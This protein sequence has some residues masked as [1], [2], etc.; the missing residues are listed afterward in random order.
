MYS[1]V[2][3]CTPADRQPTAPSAGPGT[4]TGHTGHT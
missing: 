2:A 3:R 1:P 4:Q